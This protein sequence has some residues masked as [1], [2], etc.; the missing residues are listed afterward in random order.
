MV[1]FLL[2]IAGV[3]IFV[4]YPNTILNNVMKKGGGADKSVLIEAQEGGA[5]GGSKYIICRDGKF[6]IDKNLVAYL[7]ESVINYLKNEFGNKSF[8]MFYSSDIR[9]AFDAY[10]TFELKYYANSPAIDLKGSVLFN[11]I[12]GGIKNASKSRDWEKTREYT[13]AFYNINRSFMKN[14]PKTEIQEIA[15]GYIIKASRWTQDN[16]L[17]LFNNDERYLMYADK[18]FSDWPILNQQQLNFIDSI[19]YPIKTYK[20]KRDNYFV[21]DNELFNISINNLE[22]RVNFNYIPSSQNLLPAERIKEFDEEL[23]DFF[24][25]ATE[26]YQSDYYSLDLY[27]IR[28]RQLNSEEMDK[29]AQFR[30]QEYFYINK[31]DDIY[32]LPIKFSKR[33]QTPIYQYIN[34]PWVVGWSIKSAIDAE[35]W[36][37]DNNLFPFDLIYQIGEI[38]YALD[39]NLIR[40]RQKLD[41]KQLDFVNELGEGLSYFVVD[42]KLFSFNKYMGDNSLII[43]RYTIDDVYKLV[44]ADIL[45]VLGQ[46]FKELYSRIKSGEKIEE[47]VIANQNQI[48]AY[49]YLPSDLAYY[50][51]DGNQYKILIASTS[52]RKQFISPYKDLK[53]SSDF[54]EVEIDKKNILNISKDDLELN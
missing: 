37:Y 36:T 42:N 52:I 40:N 53:E 4:Y 1:V 22:G 6:F 50:E 24:V 44:Q 12:S 48:N 54:C 38:N 9:D 11:N 8:N 21:K 31:G 27:E 20:P 34:M 47:N 10:Q 30:S 23:Y 3:I 51:K 49:K 39:D 15:P 18:P 46:N 2:I 13:D 43:K 41:K 25:D 5:W 28:Y 35:E 14:I 45:N 17:F 32:L 16:N 19:D 7:D 33:E 29:Y 26:N